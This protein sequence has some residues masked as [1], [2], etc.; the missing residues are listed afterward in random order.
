KWCLDCP[1]SADHS[2]TKALVQSGN[3]RQRATGLAL[4]QAPL[5][6]H[7]PRG[8]P[9]SSW[10]AHASLLE[11]ADRGARSKR[12]L[13]RSLRDRARDGQ[14][15]SGGV[16]RSRREPRPFSRLSPSGPI[17]MNGGVSAAVLALALHAFVV[18]G[19]V[20]DDF[21]SL[22]L[23]LVTGGLAALLTL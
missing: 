17:L 20:S 21:P 8:H 6:R 19:R 16:R 22:R 3:H 12:A 18:I 4:H 11:R 23:A 10:R 15:H 14:H 9:S 7:D 1:Q 5:P 2:S 13:S